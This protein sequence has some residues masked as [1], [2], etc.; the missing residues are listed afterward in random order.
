MPNWRDVLKE[1]SETQNQARLAFD[2]VRQKYLQKLHE[3]TGRNVI[4]YYSGWQSKPGVSG[5]EIRDEDRNGFMTVVHQLPKNAGLDL[6][7]HTPGGGIAATQSIVLYL[8]EKFDGN[9]RAII[10]HTAMS[11]G[12]IMACSCRE[13]LMARHSSIGPIDPQIRGIPAAGVIAEFK[14]IFDEIVQDPR[15]QLVWGP[16]LAQYTP[17]FIGNCENAIKWSEEF[18]R[19]QLAKNMFSKSR[20]RKKKIDSVI[21]ALT[22]YDEVKL[23]ERQI[24]Y[25]QAKSIGLNVSLIEKD[26]DL[27]DLILTVHHCYMHTLSNT[28]AFKIIENNLGVAFI[29]QMA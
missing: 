12:T 2:S 18:T 15:K 20:G 10:P 5:T 21:K 25:K 1:I 4:A 7:I 14:R 22:D 16:I 17:T 24:N 8:Q 19:E 9:I 29:K 28:Q 11:A 23:H 13:I 6:I 26:Q 27:Q 3:K